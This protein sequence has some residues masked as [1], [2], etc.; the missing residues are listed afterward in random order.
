MQVM[1]LSPLHP[2]GNSPNVIKAVEMAKQKQIKVIALLGKGGGKLRDMV[3]VPLV[4]PVTKNTDRVQEV[5]NQ[6]DPPLN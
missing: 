6:I 4:V 3:D 5:H 1:F 2:S